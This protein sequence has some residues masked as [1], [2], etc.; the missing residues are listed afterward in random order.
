[1]QHFL[2]LDIGKKIASIRNQL[3]RWFSKLQSLFHWMFL[4]VA[5]EQ[6]ALSCIAPM[7]RQGQCLLTTSAAGTRFWASLSQWSFLHSLWPVN[8]LLN[9]ERLRILPSLHLLYFSKHTLNKHQI[10]SKKELLCLLVLL[11]NVVYFHQ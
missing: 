6:Y 3:N 9:S 4:R 5:W 7:D 8:K 11:N 2:E 1:M 10:F